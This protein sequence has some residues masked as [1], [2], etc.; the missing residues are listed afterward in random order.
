MQHKLR[1]ALK[2]CVYG[3][4][5]TVDSYKLV[6]QLHNKTS[7]PVNYSV[8]MTTVMGSEHMFLYRVLQLCSVC[9]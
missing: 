6:S 4:V 1:V 7:I 9:V 8:G 3:L 2:S 5:C